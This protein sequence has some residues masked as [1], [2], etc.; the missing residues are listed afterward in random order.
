[1]AVHHEP[2]WTCVDSA[3]SSFPELARMI[4]GFHSREDM[5]RFEEDVAFIE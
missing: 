4:V 1:M 2:D 5:V 3:V